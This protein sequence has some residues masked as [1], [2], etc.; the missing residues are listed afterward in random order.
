MFSGCDTEVTSQKKNYVLSFRVFPKK[1]SITN[2]WLAM[3][4]V[5]YILPHANVL[6]LLR[7]NTLNFHEWPSWTSW[8]TKREFLLTISIQYQPDKLWE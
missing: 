8:V 2:K 4:T 5:K 7:V 1:Q 3:R 6:T